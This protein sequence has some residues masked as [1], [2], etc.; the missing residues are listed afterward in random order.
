[1]P[2]RIAIALLSPAMPSVVLLYGIIFGFAL[3]S[4]FGWPWLRSD[5]VTLYLATSA[6]AVVVIAC[7][8]RIAG[9]SLSQLDV[10]FCTF[11]LV[12]LGSI[13]THW[14]EGT[15]RYVELMPCFFVLPFALGRMM[16]VQ[17][18]K[19]FQNILIGMGGILLLF[20]PIEYW[21][22]LPS[23]SGA[24]VHPYPILFGQG[25]G[26]MLSNIVFSSALVA[27]VSMLVLLSASHGAAGRKEKWRRFFGYIMVALIIPSMAWIPNRGAALIA[28]SGVMGVL[29]VSSYCEWR[30]RVTVLLYVSLFV[31]VT[32]FWGS[33][34]DFKRKHYWDLLQSPTDMRDISGDGLSGQARP[35]GDGQSILDDSSCA[36]LREGS[37]T[38]TVATRWI[39]YRAAWDIFRANPWSGVGANSYGSYLCKSPHLHPHSTILHVLAE[40]GVPGG[41]VY[42]SMIGMA[43]W[44]LV[45]R[46][47]F[48]TMVCVKAST[49]WVLAFA[50]M[51][52]A[53]AQLYGNYFVSASLYF[54]VGLAASFRDDIERKRRLV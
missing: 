33:Q 10:I 49:G 35:Q 46:L 11:L 32:V 1:M 52:L 23:A 16:N 41:L 34:D 18:V 7:R 19:L 8:Q 51:Q 9:F 12:V 45:R 27:L 17:D 14:R 24:S 48:S 37:L 22:N 36:H 2:S 21:R 40:L 38:D 4:Y 53:L 25:H 47:L 3:W 43:F 39:L 29:L 6:W 31:V 30:R 13:A 44:V 42:F 20:M 28:A 50:V 54:V 15:A 26:A 5:T